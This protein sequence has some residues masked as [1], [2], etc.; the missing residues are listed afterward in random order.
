MQVIGEFARAVLAEAG[1]LHEALEFAPVFLHIPARRRCCCQNSGP[2]GG[3]GRVIV[4]GGLGQGTA[5]DTSP[6]RCSCRPARGRA[7]GMRKPGV[8]SLCSVSGT[9]SGTTPRSSA[10]TVV[11][12]EASSTTR[13]ISSPCAWLAA[14]CSGVSSGNCLKPGRRPPVLAAACASVQRQKLRVAVGRPGK[15]IDAEEAE[16]VV[17]AVEMEDFLRMLPTRVRHQSKLRRRNSSQR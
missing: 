6:D 2:G 10:T 17:N 8:L 11:S 15:G 12:P 5:A 14:L 3:Q 9:Y 4:R 16:R 7:M 1:K 13:R